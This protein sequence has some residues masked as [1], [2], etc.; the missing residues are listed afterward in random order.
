MSA[1]QIYN[2]ID[3][4]AAQDSGSEDEETE[5]GGERSNADQPPA[6]N[7]P[8]APVTE[9]GIGQVLDAPALD[10]ETPTIEEQVR[11]WD[12]LKEFACLKNTV[13]LVP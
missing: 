3:S 6:D 11:E 5:S 1:E 7:G 10:S 2:L 8:F 12:S 13:A 9:G 4:E